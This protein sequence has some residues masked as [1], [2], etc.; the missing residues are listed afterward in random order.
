MHCYGNT[1][2]GTPVPVRSI[3]FSSLRG[4]DRSSVG[5]GAV[6]LE[7]IYHKTE[8]SFRGEDIIAP[9]YTVGT[10]YTQGKDKR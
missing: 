5:V 3:K 9:L 1:M 7:I 6:D 10:R 8:K 2:L 4:L